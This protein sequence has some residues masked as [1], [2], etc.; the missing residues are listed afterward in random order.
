MGDQGLKGVGRRFA[1]TLR[2]RGGRMAVVM[3][4]ML[5]ALLHATGALHMPVLERLDQLIYDV[6]LRATM[7]RTL[8]ERIVIVDIDE[9]SLERVGHWPWGRDRMARFTRELLE[10][11]QAA[12]LGFD[13]VFAEPDGSSGLKNLQQLAQGPLR[14]QPGFAEQLARLAPELDFDAQFARS[15]EGQSVVLGYYFTSDRDG[16]AR[17]ILPAPTLDTT[18]LQGRQLRATTW[19]GYGS[20]IAPLAQ[21]APMAG[22]FNAMNDADGV[23]RSLPLLAEYQGQY[24]ESLALAVFRAL[25]DKPQ[26][27]PVFARTSPSGGPEPLQGIELHQ[28]GRAMRLPVDDQLA[29]LVPYRGPGGPQGGSFR[30]I[31]AADIL[32]GRLAA[33][34]LQGQI[35]LVGSTAPGLQDLRATPVDG[36]YPGVETHA[37]VIAG[38]L[39]GAGTVRPDYAAGFDVFQIACTGLLLALALPMLGAGT[40]VVLSSAMMAGLV[41]LNAWLYQTH[42]LAMPLATV[43]LLVLLAYALNMSYGYFV[44]S[45]TKRGLAQLFGTYV[46]PELVDEMVLEPERYSMQAASRE[47]TVMF[48]DMRG[49]TAMSERMEPVQLQ[50]LLNTIFTRLTR[51]IRSERGTIDKYMGDCVMAFWGAPV[52]APE[53]ATMAVRAALGMVQ[54]VQVLNEEH[55]QLDLPAIGVGVGLN[56]GAMCVGDMGSDIRRSYTVIGDAVNLGSRLEGLCKVYGVEIVASESTHAQARGFVWQELDRVCV[57]GKE[58]A[59]AIYRP[60]A[61]LGMLTAAQKHALDIWH[62]W[63]GAFRAQDWLRCDTLWPALQAAGH[64]PALLAFYAQ[65]LQAQRVLPYIPDWDGATHFDTK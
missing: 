10:R 20:N 28:D 29:T 54:E 6:R 13:I 43:L 59:V 19:N 17:G 34:S 61:P 64:A 11:Q 25:L 41:G 30:Y 37:N 23:V 60:V 24:Y 47:L 52:A 40:A 27:R 65:R 42:G 38:F 1:G 51:I 39:D 16:K 14:G 26:V 48:C 4:P 46:P 44:E 50:A 22:F 33:A 8:D 57:K 63:L 21:A 35:V 3:L 32:E 9:Q 15:L 5:L 2:R 12:V 36:A 45:R 31:P 49:F 53:H 7:P 55:R 56:T 18:V 62:E 58:Q